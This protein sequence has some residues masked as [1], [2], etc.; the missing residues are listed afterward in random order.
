MRVHVRTYGDL[1]KALSDR[2]TVALNE[3]STVK[4]LTSKLGSIVNPADRHLFQEERI[5]G[6]RVTILI[7]GQNIQ[8][9][10]QLGTELHNGDV[11]TFIPLVDG[12]TT[13]LV[14]RYRFR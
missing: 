12:G 9:L 10:Q 1:R 14:K 13:V 3:R 7:N 2:I 8:A 5:R 6:S 11:V 4:Q